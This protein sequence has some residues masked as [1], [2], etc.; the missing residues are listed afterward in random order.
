[1]PRYWTLLIILFCLLGLL[2]LT[3]TGCA[4][5]QNQTTVDFDTP[6]MVA[7]EIGDVVQ[8]ID[9]PGLLV[10]TKEVLLG[11]EA[12]GSLKEVLVEPGEFVQANQ[13]LAGLAN[14]N[15]L[16]T[17]VAMAQEACLDAQRELQAILENAPLATAQAQMDLAKAQEELQQ[18]LFRNLIQQEGNRAS[19]ATLAAAQAE[20]TLADEEIR[21]AEQEFKKLSGRPEND[22]LRASAQL[23]LAEALQ[24]R[25]SA[26]RAYN[27]YTGHPSELQQSILDA[28]IATAQARVLLAEM[29]WER[30]KDGPDA[31]ILESAQVKLALAEHR[32]VEAETQREGAALRAP[33]AGVILE[34]HAQPGDQVTPGAGI[35][36]LSDIT[37]MEVVASVIE[38]DFPQI[39][40][41]QSVELFFDARPDVEI[42]GQI[43]RI[44]PKRLPG[45]RPLYAVQISFDQAPDGLVPGMTADASI[46][47][48]I[49]KDVLRLPKSLVH[50]RSDGT[51]RLEVWVDD[52][53]EE[54]NVWVGLRGDSYVEILS[55]LQAGDLVISDFGS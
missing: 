22:T 7:V 53:R 44:V 37:A 54:R 16:D 8:S 48:A 52:H 46:I 32:L 9:A 28:E 45:D 13:M 23:R 17:A 33:F 27:W 4:N 1:M 3:A 24:R 29:A 21:L 19:S 6:D 14:E 12:S 39:Q 15:A 5:S 34:V 30:V 43:E 38:E 18:T 35:I 11:M 36:L 26:Q 51:A 31:M 2:A 10:A 41:G 40:I 50:S 20:L 47:T 42:L 49:Q 55:G 25:D